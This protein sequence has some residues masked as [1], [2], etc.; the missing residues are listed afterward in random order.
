MPRG[1]QAGAVQ[2]E[3]V[4]DLTA[5]PDD[6]TEDEESGTLQDAVLDGDEE[7]EGE[8]GKDISFT[9]PALMFRRSLY[10]ASNFV[11]CQGLHMR[12]SSHDQT[13]NASCLI[14]NPEVLGTYTCEEL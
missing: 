12:D 11:R 9:I 10:T 4:M 8:A 7:E 14:S 5:D 6:A 3:E 1:A 2:A 13:S